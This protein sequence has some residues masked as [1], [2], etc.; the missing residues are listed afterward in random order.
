MV[1]LIEGKGVIM[2][3]FLKKTLL[4]I[5][6]ACIV[7]VSTEA[8]YVKAESMTPYQS[9]SEVD[10]AVST[11][12]EN[13]IVIPRGIAELFERFGYSED[14][15]IEMIRIK[16][17]LSESATLVIEGSDDSSD[18]EEQPEAGPNI[19]DVSAVKPDTGSNQNNARTDSVQTDNKTS[20]YVGSSQN[21]NSFSSAM[22][23]FGQYGKY[24][25]K[26]SE[27]NEIT[28]GFA[29]VAYENVRDMLIDDLTKLGTDEE[30]VSEYFFG[31]G[32]ST[33]YR[34]KLS[35]INHT[36][37][38]YKSQ[39]ELL[40]TGNLTDVS[41]DD[42]I[43]KSSYKNA[44]GQAKLFDGI[45]LVFTGVNVFL[46]LQE[47]SS[48]CDDIVND[49]YYNEKT[50]TRGLEKTLLFAGLG[51]D[52]VSL[53]LLVTG[54]ACPPLAVISLITSLGIAVVHN[55]TFADLA[56]NSNSL[57]EF[58]SN[59]FAYFFFN[60]KQANS[61]GVYKPNIY[62]YNALG[63]DI[64]V[65]MV[66]PELLTKTI[67]DYSG[68][69][70]VKATGNDSRLLGED[71]EEYGYLFYES[72][73]NRSLFQ[74]KEGFSITRGNRA[75]IFENIL[76]EYGFNETEIAD[77][78]EFWD[79]K[80]DKDKDY[81]MYPQYTEAVDIAMPVKITPYPEGIV[82][83]WFAF[84]EDTGQEYESPEIAPFSHEGYCVIEW[85]GMIF[86]TR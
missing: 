22:A 20:D 37:N 38:K 63:K 7:L 15:I 55:Q 8:M 18:E 16:A 75:S 83:M 79:E 6:S 84:V 64:Y 51:M 25:S 48:Y 9:V 4:C 50:F 28:D 31:K 5:L 14:E 27:S 57:G 12:E 35:S 61:V 17:N 49:N 10:S 86:S 2:R 60:R 33:R 13:T 78:V 81:V 36:I 26:I 41:I 47:I 66:K 30:L 77:F 82:R 19:R 58:L 68:G 53:G 42:F 11:N 52:M 39:E 74:E 56:N 85:G 62:I 40:K 70:N 32:F 59:L 65:K 76:K 46:T 72:K 69:W 3:N 1:L 23:S 24:Y 21:K 45:G 71:G 67:P 80:L 44:V 29:G 54:V 73:T 34:D 43:S